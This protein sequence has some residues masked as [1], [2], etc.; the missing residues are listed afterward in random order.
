MILFDKNELG[1]IAK[2]RGFVRDTYEKVLRL[3]EVLRFLNE[4]PFLK[5]HLVL[6]GGTAINLTIVDMP[7]MSV[8]I[9]MDMVPNETKEQMQ[10]SREEITSKIVSHMNSEGYTLSPASR[11]S[12]SLDAFLFNYRNSGGNP[13]HLKIEINYSLR[14]HLF[15]PEYRL[16]K[17]KGSITPFSI[18]TVKT[19]EIYAAKANALLSRAAARDLFDFSYMARNG[20]M[21]GNEALFRKAIIFYMTISSETLNKSF[22]VSAIDR[23]TMSMIKRDLLPV[24]RE[25]GHFDLDEHKQICKDYIS[26]LM[27]PSEKEMEYM[28]RFEKGEYRPELLFDDSEIVER[29]YEHPMALWKCN[30]AE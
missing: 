2:E 29:I 14:S 24:L 10:Q 28:L 26:S 5:E 7:R 18:K 25:K 21:K 17:V 27:K 20:L 30:Y 9:D 13:D 22:D 4:E 23:L 11:H 6:K 16:L 8:D 19:M 1:K 3:A 12:F 15:I